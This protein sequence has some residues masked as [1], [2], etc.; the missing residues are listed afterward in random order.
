MRLA[1]DAPFPKSRIDI[2]WSDSSIEEVGGMR[3]IV[4]K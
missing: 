3:F 4:Y 2:V 1:F